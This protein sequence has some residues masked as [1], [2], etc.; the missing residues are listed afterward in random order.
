MITVIGW[1]LIVGGIWIAGEIARAQKEA[2]KPALQPVPVRN[3]KPRQR[4]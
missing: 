3:Q 1:G 2:K 4:R